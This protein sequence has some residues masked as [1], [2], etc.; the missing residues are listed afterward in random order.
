MLLVSLKNVIFGYSH[1]PALNDVSFDIESGE[2]VGIT[3]PNG[4]SKSTM[5]KL[6]LGLLKPWE[7][8][9]WRS[10][11]NL[12][13]ERLTIGYVPQ[14]IAS[15]NAGFPSTVME[16]VRSGRYKRGKWFKRLDSYDLTMMER[17]LKMVGMWE[18][19]H[20]KIGAL[21]GGQKQKICIARVLASDPDLLVLDEPTTGM[22]TESRK[23]F[24]E[25]LAHQVEEHERTVIMI[26][27]NQ[28]EAEPYLTK[29]IQLERREQEGW[30]CLIL[31]SCNGHFGPGESSH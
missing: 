18:F 17:A 23:E 3:G 13:G 10:K 15:F 12:H 8:T 29:L 16:L 28:D 30:K 5:I 20:H 2:F 1:V 25:F 24:Y 4:A 19:R 27:H 7:G 21:S 6:M 31:N 11:K 14:Q 26:T 22:D 9:V